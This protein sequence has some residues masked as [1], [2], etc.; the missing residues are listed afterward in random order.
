[1]VKIPLLKTISRPKNT[2]NR[3]KSLP[4]NAIILLHKFLPFFLPMH[5]KNTINI[6]SH[7]VSHK[8]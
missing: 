4:T 6:P 1:M 5:T 3:M 2:T 8:K 7:P